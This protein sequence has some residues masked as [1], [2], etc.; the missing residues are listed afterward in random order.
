M[1]CTIYTFNAVCVCVHIGELLERCQMGERR[2]KEEEEEKNL[3][4]LLLLL[5]FRIFTV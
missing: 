3:P 1:F 2:L 5:A 4:F